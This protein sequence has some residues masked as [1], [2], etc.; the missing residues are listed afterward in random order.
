VNNLFHL[1][2]SVDALLAAITTAW[3]AL[4]EIVTAGALLLALDR[5]AA[6]IRFTYRCG[7]AVGTAW[8]RWGL[9]ALLAAADAISWINSQ[10]DWAEVRDTVIAG[11]KVLIAAAITLAITA[12]QLLIQLSAALGRAYAALTVRQP[13]VTTAPAAPAV[14]PLALVAAGLEPL[15]HRQL[16]AITGCRRRVAKQQLIAAALAW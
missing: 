12:H 1:A 11:L 15:S 6:A 13:I 10:I 9:P 5:L 3:A 14:H 4:G 2:A 16:Q 7:H 8:F